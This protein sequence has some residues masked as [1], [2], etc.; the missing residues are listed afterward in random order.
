MVKVERMEGQTMIYKTL[1]RKLKIAQ[2]ATSVLTASVFSTSFSA[3]ILG[4]APLIRITDDA[5][6]EE[7]EEASVEK[8][9][10][11]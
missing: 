11:K 2:M 1:H 8:E 4:I 6:S 10:A 9:T 3:C 7:V 5:S